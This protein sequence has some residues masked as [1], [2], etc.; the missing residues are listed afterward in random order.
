M[1]Q[2]KEG[3]IKLMQEKISSML[4]SDSHFKQRQE[5]LD[6]DRAERK[7]EL[8]KYLCIKNTYS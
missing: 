8:S 7:K 6:A 2:E 1:I 5:A 3:E 4:L